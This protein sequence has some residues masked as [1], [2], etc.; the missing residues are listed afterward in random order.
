MERYQQLREAD[1][2]AGLNDIL[3]RI[4]T[5]REPLIRELALCESRRGEQPTAADLELNELR[6]AADR[7]L[8]TLFGARISGRRIVHS[9]TEWR[10]RLNRV[11][12]LDWK[13]VESDLLQRLI[14]DGRRARQR[15]SMFDD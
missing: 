3:S 6:A 12:D 9:E 5:E 13:S 7:M 4:V 10:E 8:G 14:A 2:D 11:R 1:I 15:L